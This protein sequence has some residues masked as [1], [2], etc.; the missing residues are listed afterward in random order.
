MVPVPVVVVWGAS[1]LASS[2]LV[3]IGAYNMGVEDGQKQA[4]VGLSRLLSDKGWSEEEL[5]A[6]DIH[7]VLGLHP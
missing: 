5:R 1:V 4:V 6:L 7:G 3:G 2:T